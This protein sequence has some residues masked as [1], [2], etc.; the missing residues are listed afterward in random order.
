MFC[1]VKVNLIYKKIMLVTFL[2]KSKIRTFNLLIY[3]ALPKHYFKNCYMYLTTEWERGRG[4]EKER[5]RDREKE[6]E[7]ERPRSNWLA[8]SAFDPWCGRAQESNARVSVPMG[9]GGVIFP[10]GGRLSPEGGASL[11][12]SLPHTNTY[13]R[14]DGGLA[15]K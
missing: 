14:Q 12:L 13:T 1:E 10:R 6:I 3:N 7:R 5:E 9:T 11:S 2:G 4:R 8:V 15:A